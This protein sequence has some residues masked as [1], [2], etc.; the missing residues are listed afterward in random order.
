MLLLV[1]TAQSVMLNGFAQL[2]SPASAPFEQLA[3]GQ[4]QQ[5]Q[6]P[7]TTA[8]KPGTILLTTFPNGT[9]KA[10]FVN[11]T[12]VQP[13]SGVGY[14]VLDPS[15]SPEAL[16]ASAPVS[17]T[18]VN[19]VYQAIAIA[20]GITITPPTNETNGN[21]T[22]PI[23]PR[24]NASEPTG[25]DGRC[26]FDPSLPHCAPIDGECPDGFGM[27]EDE[28]CFPLGGCPDGY[29]SV[30]DDETG[31]CYP[32]DVPCPD[33]QVMSGEGNYCK[34][35]TVAEPIECGEGFV[36]NIETGMCEGQ[37]QGATTTPP[38][39]ESDRNTADSGSEN[40]NDGDSSNLS[41]ESASEGGDNRDDQG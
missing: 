16:P 3:Q 41:D 24:P 19:R 9:S 17:N 13:V 21:I 38:P 22:I 7:L 37:Q 14:L 23:P 28:Q 32:D 15:A 27:N 5:Q 26:L 20:I 12:T 30:E 25:P 10:Q 11:G 35:P 1:V 2:A 36:L 8:S 39:D 18:V 31:T 4:Q 34:F 40:G 6:Q 33:G 29:H